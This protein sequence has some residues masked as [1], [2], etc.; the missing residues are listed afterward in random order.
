MKLLHSVPAA[1]SSD[2]FFIPKGQYGTFYIQFD[3]IA[4][5]GVTLTREDFGN[6]ILNWNGQD[7]IN[8]D[9]EI[10]NLLDN[11][12]GGTSKF[13]S[14][15]GADASMACFLTAGLWFD[16]SNVY[17]IGG[18]DKVYIKLDFP[19]LADSAK[20]ASG[21]V[22]IYAKNKD[23]IMNY[24]HNITARPVPASGASTLADSF[25]VNN[26]TQVYL[27]DPAA[28]TSNLQVVKDG[29]TLVDAPPNE[30]I[31]YSDFIHQ[32]E[33]TSN[34]LAIDFV[35]SRSLAEA[36][37]STISY[38]Y[39]F[40]GAGTLQQYFSFIDFTP[41]KANESGNTLAKKQVPI[42]SAPN[43]RNVRDIGEGNNALNPVFSSTGKRL[44]PGLAT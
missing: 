29:I 36:V 22:K 27:K 41:A 42:L 5:A 14:T 11:V 31:N 2:T 16:S 32:L 17:D 43:F 24:L 12:Y 33:T 4:Q 40:T 6:I 25:P 15:V 1:N 37:G 10:I 44:P 38:K 20:V 7:V 9:A 34:T 21:Q 19:N 8:V 13:S 26:V 35:E 3:V 39:T 18:N 30:L 23:G 28:L